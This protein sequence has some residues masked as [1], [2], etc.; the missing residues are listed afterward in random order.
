[1]IDKRARELKKNGVTIQV[2]Y[3]V[4]CVGYFQT[5]KPGSCN[6]FDIRYLFW[7]SK[8]I[9]FAQRFDNCHTYKPVEIKE[10]L[11][12]KIADN[13]SEIKKAEIKY[14]QYVIVGE[15]K[16]DTI[17]LMVDHSCHYI[18]N[19]F[20]GNEKID[21]DI[22]DYALETKELNDYSGNA[23]NEP[24]K[25]HNDNYEINQRSI[26]VELKNMAEKITDRINKKAP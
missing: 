19:I 26:L 22:D 16:N 3:Y 12:D 2:Q 24:Q 14:P 8:G 6:I 4:D 20:T 21:K 1:M 5:F 17:S 25:R 10:N 15:R 11:I 7:K 18:F 9:N 13:L 23:K